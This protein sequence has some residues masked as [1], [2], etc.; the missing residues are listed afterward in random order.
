[1]EL[2]STRRATALLTNLPGKVQQIPPSRSLNGL[3]SLQ[4]LRRYSTDLGAEALAIG[5]GVGDKVSLHD[6]HPRAFHLFSPYSAEGIQD[7]QSYASV[8]VL[9][10]YLD[11]NKISDKTAGQNG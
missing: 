8:F 5:V 2:I 10:F 3:C 4:E 1:M 11:K 6:Y 9:S 7:P